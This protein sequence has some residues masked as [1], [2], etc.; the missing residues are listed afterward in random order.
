MT[1]GCM[2]SG[3]SAGHGGPE[4]AQSRSSG[5]KGTPN[6]AMDTGVGRGCLTLTPTPGPTPIPPCPQL[7]SELSPSLPRR[8]AQVTCQSA[9]P[10]PALRQ[11]LR[12][13]EMGWGCGWGE[14]PSARPS[15]GSPCGGRCAEMLGRPA[16]A[17]E[18]GQVP[19]P[20]LRWDYS[21]LAAPCPPGWPPPPGSGQNGGPC[22][23]AL[24]AGS[25]A[26]S[27]FPC[28][29]G[30]VGSGQGCP[31]GRRGLRAQEKTSLHWP[32]EA[33]PTCRALDVS[34]SLRPS[35]WRGEGVA[36]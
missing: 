6:V 15:G 26:G 8:R 27:Q 14:S 35:Y 2:G 30:G 31:G 5:L 20:L 36:G 12:K 3:V 11:G 10:S 19:K 13:E 33:E 9:Q 7:R 28:R 4:P 17:G 29:Q 24:A 23:A 18:A 1:P 32:P 34:P 22:R 16:G 21:H 25:R